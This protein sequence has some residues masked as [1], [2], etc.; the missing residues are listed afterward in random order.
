MVLYLNLVAL[1][2]FSLYK[3]KTD[4]TKQTAVAYTSTIIIFLVL[5]GVIVYHVYL[6]IR[7]KTTV[8]VVQNEYHL[9]PVEPAETVVTYS[10]VEILESQC[11]EGDGQFGAGDEKECVQWKGYTTVDLK[12]ALL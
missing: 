11:P 3:F 12:Q 2:A 1:A 6:L 4:P 5:V 7:K 8:T 10:V 9:A